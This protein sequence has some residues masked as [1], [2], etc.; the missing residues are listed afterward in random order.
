MSNPNLHR[1]NRS[2]TTAGCRDTPRRAIRGI[3]LCLIWLTAGVSS[4][5]LGGCTPDPNQSASDA[6]TENR[7]LPAPDRTSLGEAVAKAPADST[8]IQFTEIS[9]RDSG[10]AFRHVSGNS[11]DKP[12]P[13]ANGSGVGAVDFDLDGRYDLYFATGRP[14]PFDRETDGGPNRLYRNLGDWKF[15]D[16]SEPAGLA[17]RRYSSGITVG[18]FNCDG[19]PDLFVGCFGPNRLFRNLGDGTF[20]EVSASAGVDDQRWATSAAF[21]DLDGDGLPDLYVCNYAKW[22]FAENRFCGDRARNIRMYCNPQSVPGETDVLYRNNGDGTF[23]DVTKKWGL[24]RIARRGQGVLAADVDGD[25]LMD[26]YVGNDVHLN[27]LLINRPD[28]RFKDVSESSGAGCDEGGR[29]QASM[30]VAGGDVNRDG[31]WDLFTTNFEGE[32]N[33]LYI[34]NA[35]G[36]FFDEGKVRGIAADSRPWVGWGTAFADFNLDAWPDLIV[37]NGHVDDNLH[38]FGRNSPYRQPALV[39]KNVSGRFQ[40][41]KSPGSYFTRPHPGRG[42]CTVDL[43]NDG[44]VDV[45][46]S[47][48]DEA[49]ALLRNER[50]TGRR[51]K[52]ALSVT[53]R[54]IGVRSTRDAFGA[55]VE[56]ASRVASRVMQ[57]QGGGSYLSASDLRLIAAAVDTRPL[58]VTIRWPSG[59]VSHL[60][61]ISPGGQYDIIE[62][63]GPRSRTR[64]YRR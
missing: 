39:W 28:R 31:R 36:V 11:K 59:V 15:D 1:C 29:L 54:L 14:F 46:V 63:A 57:I 2:I 42:L 21:F 16:V 8:G 6:G 32:F 56:I 60:S 7:S 44:D 43:D 17:L 19:F 61:G 48:Q 49:P 9:L 22:S 12:F 25:G 33:A 50:I 5:W 37:T 38:S 34:Q 35:A 18:D 62:P 51:E 40:R 27:M 3:L 55:R 52:R 53:L 10:V 45:V 30:G 20:D 26:L 64:L 24:D 58:T 4:V 13:A 23:S 47:H 41:V